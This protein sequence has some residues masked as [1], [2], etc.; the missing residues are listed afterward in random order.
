MCRRNRMGASL[1]I[2]SQEKTE[3]A[4]LKMKQNHELMMK[5]GKVMIK[6]MRHSDSCNCFCI[7]SS[8]HRFIFDLIFCIEI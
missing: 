5:G 3:L 1:S 4:L 8:G 2:N 7:R 6:E